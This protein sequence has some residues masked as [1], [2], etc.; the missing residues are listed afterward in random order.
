MTFPP[1][2]SEQ[3]TV[4]TVT[5]LVAS[6]K[7]V[8]SALREEVVALSESDQHS[9]RLLDL[10]LTLLGIAVVVSLF[11]VGLTYNQAS[12]VKSIVHY[13]SDCQRPD[14][15]CRQQQD[16]VIG[17]AVNNIST[18]SFDSISCVLLTPPEKRTNE[19]VKACRD[20]YLGA[21]K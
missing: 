13:I 7:E 1:S 11:G 10:K 21:K 5:L 17:Q 16:A 9:R 4:T 6:L 8:V 12:N 18:K 2:P 3:E 15:K 20:K 19:S 14:S